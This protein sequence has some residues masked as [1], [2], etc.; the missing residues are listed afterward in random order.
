MGFMVIGNGRVD[1]IVLLYGMDRRD[2]FFIELFCNTE[3]YYTEIEVF[4]K[5]RSEKMRTA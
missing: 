3:L 4:F 5:T 1:W 2:V